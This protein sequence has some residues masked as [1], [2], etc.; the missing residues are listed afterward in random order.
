M[1]LWLRTLQ[2]FSTPQRM[3]AQNPLK[4]FKA[5]CGIALT[6]SSLCSTPAALVASAN[7]QVLA[8][9]MC[10]CVCAKLLQS[11]P[12]FCDPMEAIA[13]QAP[14]SMGFSRQEDWSGLPCTRK[15]FRKRLLSREYLAFHFSSDMNPGAGRM[16]SAW[17]DDREMVWLARLFPQFLAFHTTAW[18]L[19]HDPPWWSVLDKDVLPLDVDLS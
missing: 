7:S 10:V 15:V 1:P 3:N 13:G 4:V 17:K 12:T 18:M 11:R 16:G 9:G 5:L 2:W 19:S 8:Q 14:L 6:V